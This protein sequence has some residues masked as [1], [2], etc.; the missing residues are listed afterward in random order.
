MKC[1]YRT[2]YFLVSS[3]LLGLTLPSSIASSHLPLF[4]QQEAEALKKAMNIMTVIPKAANDMMNVGRLQGFDVSSDGCLDCRSSQP[5]A[6][7]SEL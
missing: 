3:V 7:I 2:V 4:L 1:G 5:I 6:G